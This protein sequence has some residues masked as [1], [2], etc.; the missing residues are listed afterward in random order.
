MP[1]QEDPAS[2]SRCI[3]GRLVE[4]DQGGR[5]TK[6]F[7]V[8]VLAVVSVALG[9]S[10]VLADEISDASAESPFVLTIYFE[11]DGTFAKPNNNTDRHYTNGVKLTFA[12]Q[13]QWAADLAAK[14]PL[15][16]QQGGGPLKTAVGYAFGQNIYTPDGI[17]AVALIPDDRPYAGWLYV[18]AYLQRATQSEFDHL[19]LNVGLIGPSSLAEDVQR[20]IHDTFDEPK[21]RGWDNQLGDELG[22]NVTYQR[23]WKIAMWTD[24]VWA[25]ELIP[26]AGFTLGTINRHANIGVLAR[27]GVALPDDFGPGRIEEPA[28][29]TTIERSDTGGYLFIRLGGK[30]VE[31]NTFLEG[32]N[33]KSSHGVNAE[34]LLGE[35]QVGVVVR[36]R[37]VELG[38]SQTFM[39]REFKG[40][41]GTDSFGA[42]TLSFK[43]QF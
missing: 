2:S 20:I 34:P 16:P 39:S 14:L 18:G 8:V 37:R 21:P 11:N 1:R 3:S 7:W 40:Q 38:Y 24:D 36:W 33:Y 42:W 30:A 27:V 17:E 15:V 22:F 25:A 13:P 4:G 29:A 31:H 43:S 41:R 32:N 35:V 12:H 5:P 26:Q 6:Y 10:P 19:E 23:K 28:A 9:G